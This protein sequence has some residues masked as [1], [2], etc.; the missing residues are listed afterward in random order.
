MSIDAVLASYPKSG[1]TWLRFALSCYFARTAAL[2]AIPD[3]TTTF[4]ILPNME[5]DPLRGLPAY[6][7][8]DNPAVPLIAASHDSYDREALLDRAVIFLLRDPRDVLVSAYFHESRHHRHYEGTLKAFIRDP[9]QGLSALIAYLNGWANGLKAH[10][11]HLISYE[12]MSTD[13]AGVM[14]EVLRF[15]KIPCEDGALI[16]AVGAS[17]F[18]AM[19]QTELQGGIPGHSYDR[20]D[21]ESRRMRTGKVGGYSAYLDNEDIS[22]INTRCVAELNAA[23]LT[24]LAI[25]EADFTAG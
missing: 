14:R 22:L 24:L 6:G 3:L 12:M 23:A 13:F 10:R 19:R 1:R 15:L 21:R 2:G 11:H 20:N 8:A 25:T 17:R 16:H 9:M 18:E 5:C 7:F 4:R